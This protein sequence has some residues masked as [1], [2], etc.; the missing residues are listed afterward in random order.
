[1]KNAENPSQTIVGT[2]ILNR[3]AVADIVSTGRIVARQERLILSKNSRAH[4]NFVAG[5]H[6]EIRL[7]LMML[8][9]E[10]VYVN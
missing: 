10:P 3:G 6:F 7:R 2:E 5:V 1:M 9:L 4:R 8:P